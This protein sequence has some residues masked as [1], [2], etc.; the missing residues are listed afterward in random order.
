MWQIHWGL[1]HCGTTLALLGRSLH[2]RGALFF[3]NITLSNILFRNV[4]IHVH[5][6]SRT[7]WLCW[8]FV[9]TK[10][11]SCERGASVGSMLRL[12]LQWPVLKICDTEV[13]NFS[14][15]WVMWGQRP[16]ASK[17]CSKRY[18]LSGTWPRDWGQT[19]EN[20]WFVPGLLL[21]F[22]LV[23]GFPADCSLLS[24]YLSLS[25]LWCLY[26]SSWSLVSLSL[27]FSD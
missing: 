13:W 8:N 7:T 27:P 15:L 26:V 20:A 25:P 21:C 1:F 23:L 3:Q 4:C 11:A 24:Q 10:T 12:F 14:Q 5:S 17:R 6:H 2:N 19:Q 16:S 18:G 22:P 9:Q